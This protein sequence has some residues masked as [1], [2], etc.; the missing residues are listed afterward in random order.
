MLI[1]TLG[2]EGILTWTKAADPFHQPSFVVRAVDTIGAGD[3]CLGGILAGLSLGCD[4]R[5]AV[6]WGAACGA[7]ATTRS[8]LLA[9]LPTR[10]QLE[11]FLT[12]HA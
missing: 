2:D 4:P 10:D 6:R 12:A 1:V 7:M 5:E 11:V 8:G 9:A 3:A